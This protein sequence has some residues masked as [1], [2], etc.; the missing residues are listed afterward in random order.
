MASLEVR[1]EWS[2]QGMARMRLRRHVHWLRKHNPEQLPYRPGHCP[3]CGL[4]TEAELCGFC[5]AELEGRPAPRV[6]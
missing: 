6:D 5:M 1:R 3:N 4:R 2:R